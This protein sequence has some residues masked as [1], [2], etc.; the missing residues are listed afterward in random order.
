MSW[1]DTFSFERVQIE[2]LLTLMMRVPVHATHSLLAQCDY[3]TRWAARAVAYPAAG[4][5]GL[6]DLA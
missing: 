4:P 1:R 5:T 2:Y 6:P 3:S